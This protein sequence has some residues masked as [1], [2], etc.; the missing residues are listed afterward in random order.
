MLR[1]LLYGLTSRKMKRAQHACCALFFSRRDLALLESSAD[2]SRQQCA[3]GFLVYGDFDGSGDVTKNFDGDSLFADR[4][5][6][7]GELDLALIDF[8]A[9]RCEG[10][11]DI[12]GSD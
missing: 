3:S 8:E 1:P 2:V 5:D 9:L 12:A 10:F 11:R 4:F 6:G 7:L